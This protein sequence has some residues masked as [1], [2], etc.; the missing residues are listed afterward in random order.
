MSVFVYID[1]FVLGSFLDRFCTLFVQ[2]FDQIAALTRACLV[3]TVL[4]NSDKT[5]NLM[6][7]LGK[8]G[9]IVFCC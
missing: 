2:C 8:G 6:T 4:Q 7:F 5:V 3:K 1:V 9:F